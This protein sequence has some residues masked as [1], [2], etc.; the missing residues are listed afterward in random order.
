MTL[1][2]KF[3]KITSDH[4]ISA[5]VAPYKHYG[6]GYAEHHFGVG[7]EGT[8]LET[9]FLLTTP[10]ELWLFSYYDKNPVAVIDAKTG[11]YVW[12]GIMKKGHIRN[13]NPG[14]GFYRV[15]STKAMSVM[16]GASSCG[17]EFSPAAGLFAVDDALFA[18][19]QEI[20]ELRT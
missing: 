7:S 13:V 15:R 19:I 10:G 2:G 20:R 9:D 16:G 8:G 11:K 3:V 14:H 4:E 1:A 5:L 6:G 17:A 18:V 12:E